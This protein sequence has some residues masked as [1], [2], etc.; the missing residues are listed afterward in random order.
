MLLVLKIA[1]KNLSRHKRR[2][3]LLGALVAIGSALL[4][5]AN[6]L[7]AGADLGIE[8]A[9]R[10]GLTGD[11]VLSANEGEAYGLFGSEI[12]IVSEYESIPAITGYSSIAEKLASIDALLV[13]SPVVS[14]MAQMDLEGFSS[15][16]PLFGVNGESYF[17][18]CSSIQI[19]EMSEYW[20]QANGVLLND[21]MA[22]SI[23]LRRGRR[24]MP[25]ESIRFSLAAGNSFRLRSGV[26]AGRYRYVARTEVLDRV[27]L[28]DPNMARSLAGYTRG[29]PAEYAHSF[30]SESDV[31]LDD[32]FS[33]GLDVVASESQGLRL[34]EVESFLADT[35]DRDEAVATDSAAWSFILAK[36]KPGKSEELHKVLTQMGDV[37]DGGVRLLSWRQA[38]GTSA[39]AIFAVQ[40]AFSIGL[41]FLALGAILVMTSALSSAVLERIPEIGTMRGLGASRLFV[42][43]LL[44]SE[45][46]FVCVGGAGVGVAIGVLGALAVSVDGIALN[47]PILQALFGGEVARPHVGIAEA[48]GQLAL[49]G[50]VGASAWIYPVFLALRIA[51]AGA[52]NRGPA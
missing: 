38:A 42:A 2:T 28:V 43:S 18:V 4:L 22:A 6:S 17:K 40:I 15:K 46:L 1:I 10:R 19:T 51:P 47:N 29:V 11:F 37:R 21:A 48:F 34:G 50:A 36:A 35:R 26:Y 23:E 45:S 16:V 20:R 39:T 44:M 14:V 9:F 33:F 8:E 41:G 25:G 7:F 13:A 30:S 49:S 32:L 12:P 24:L 52:M 27:V 5:F 3:F 31:G